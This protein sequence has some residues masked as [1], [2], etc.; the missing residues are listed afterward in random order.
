VGMARPEKVLAY[1]IVNVPMLTGFQQT[2]QESSS[3][4][5]RWDRDQDNPG[6]Q[7]RYIGQFH[8]RT[9]LPKPCRCD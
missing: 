5:D 2:K 4:F 1:R 7:L 8:G 9:S 6:Q 3:E